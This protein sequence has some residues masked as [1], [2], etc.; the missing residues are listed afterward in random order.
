MLVLERRN[1]SGVPCPFCIV[2]WLCNI[3]QIFFSKSSSAVWILLLPGFLMGPTF[4]W[5][6]ERFSRLD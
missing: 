4:L 1:S 2:L 5:D 3:F 6:A